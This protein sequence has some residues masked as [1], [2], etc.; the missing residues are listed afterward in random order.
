MPGIDF[1]AK[2]KQCPECGGSI[3]V[4]K[5]KKRSVVTLAHGPFEAREIHKQCRD[6][7]CP[8]IK[9]D[10]L[11]QLVKPGQKYGYDL[12][13]QVGLWRYLDGRQ[14]EEIRRM[15][16]KNHGIELS[17][18]SVS[19]LCDRFLGYFGALHVDRAPVLRGALKDGYPMHIDATCER[20]KGGLFVCIDGWRNWVLW[21]A[22]I[23]SES[24]ENITPVIGKAVSLFGKP[25]A[26]VRD[27]GEG[28]AHSVKS[29]RKAGIPDIVCHY[30]FLAAVG[31]KLFGHRYDIL[32]SKIRQTKCRSDMRVMLQ[33]LRKYSPAVK[34]K[35]R[36]GEGTVRDAVKALVL[37]VIEGD[38]SSDA[39]FPFSLPHLRFAQR[40][41]Q[42]E[43]R[44]EKWVCQPQS[45]PERRALACL[46]RLTTLIKHTPAISELDTRWVAF[47]ELRDILRLSNAELPRGDERYIQRNLPA[48]ELLRLQKIKQ[49]VDQY[50]TDL[51][52]RIPAKEKIKK[53]PSTAAAIILQYLKRHGP[54]LFGHPATYDKEGRIVAIVERTNNI[55]EHFFGKVKQNLRRRVGRS[56][57]GRDL[58]K[59]PAEV[60]LVENLHDS[61][62]VKLLCGSLEKLPEAFARLNQKSSTKIPPLVRDHRDSQLQK[63]LLQLLCEPIQL[64]SVS[65]KN[66]QRPQP[67]I[68]PHT[69]DEIIDTAQMLEK[70]PFKEM[71]SRTT[72]IIA[73]SQTPDL[74]PKHRDPRLPPPGSVLERRYGR[75]T[76]YVQTL[77]NG[78]LWG[79]T[80][81]ATLTK[82]A[83]TITGEPHNGFEFFGLK[84]PWAQRSAKMKGRKLNCLTIIKLP[85]AT[86]S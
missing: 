14:R 25:V 20:G 9:S 26:V 36:F 35:G 21:A 29:L 56:Q 37:W 4:R 3:S 16:R 42:A 74:S 7:A 31:K 27:M 82:V 41:L 33:D 85:I 66:E 52:S 5:S 83:K 30:H 34:T 24:S 12:I 38:G 79:K 67:N 46:E 86:E 73:Q 6:N 75:R 65:C 15:L 76:Y 78:F 81:Y 28:C 11:N 2:T 50:T 43:Q 17:A 18:G 44:A 55:P 51:E 22:R 45:V 68:S 71:Q 57:L 54:K 60:A 77:D 70:L 84:I 72:A 69:I 64:P 63:V 13:V 39:P 23:P 62:Y 49:A 80:T 58:A 8:S 32:R 1:V 10:A 53:K 59:Q 61:K 19:A 47:C 40:C 48:L